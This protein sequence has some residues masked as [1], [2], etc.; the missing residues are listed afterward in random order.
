MNVIGGI[1]RMTLIISNMQSVQVE[2]VSHHCN[3]F[4]STVCLHKILRN[5]GLNGGF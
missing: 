3:K 5:C 1:I 2:Y 4:T